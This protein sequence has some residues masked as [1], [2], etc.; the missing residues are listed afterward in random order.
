M[1]VMMI[2][3]GGGANLLCTRKHILTKWQIHR[4]VWSRSATSALQ[5][6]VAETGISQYPTVN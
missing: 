6:L 1:M 3:Q 2:V 4:H 5:E